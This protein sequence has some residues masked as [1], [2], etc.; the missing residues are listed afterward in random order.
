[1]FNTSQELPVSPGEIENSFEQEILTVKAAVQN[2]LLREQFGLE[3][4]NMQQ[5]FAWIDRNGN[6]INDI[7]H[8]NP[9]LVKEYYSDPASVMARIKTEIGT[10]DTLH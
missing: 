3:Q 6:K 1:M 4:D 8:A 9:D 2:A 7:F 5:I 10:T